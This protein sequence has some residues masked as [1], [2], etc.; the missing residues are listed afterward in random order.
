MIIIMY[1]IILYI[2][3]IIDIIILMLLLILLLILWY[4][5]DIIIDMIKILLAF[6]WLDAGCM[7]GMILER[8][9]ERD[10]L[11]WRELYVVIFY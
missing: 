11:G 5:Y 4:Y 6:L 2:I 10:R 3:D 1:I 8:P 9:T 7:W